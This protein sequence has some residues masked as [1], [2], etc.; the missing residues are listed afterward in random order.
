MIQEPI[1]VAAELTVEDFLRDV[2]AGLSRP[3]KTLPCKYLYDEHG[4]SLF[5]RICDLEE[6]YPTRTEISI[7]RDNIS[8]MAALAGPRCRVIEFGSGSGIKTRLLLEHLDAPAMYVPI[9]VARAQ[10]LDC[11]AHFAREHPA[12]EVLPVCADYTNH[13]EFPEPPADSGRTL[14]FFP[15]ST[16]G[17]FEPAEA[18]E[19]LKRTAH[20]CGT[21]GGILLGVDLKKS[22]AMLYRAYNDSRGVTA[23]F[24]LNLLERI[25]RELDADFDRSLFRHLARYDEIAGRIEMHLISRQRQSVSICGM[26]FDFKAG[27]SIVTEHSY[28]YTPGEFRRLAGRAGLEVAR[29]WTDDRNW[30]SVHYLTPA[31]NLNRL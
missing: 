16:I 14:V 2:L 23:E 6:Y 5:E 30:F 12:M 19:F 31:R 7:L 9:D 21:H 18:V 22:P 4:A 15:G 11:A 24:N 27:E 1:L 17:N 29:C 8:E 26:E 3:M 28:K 13:F 25:N 10:L 20:L